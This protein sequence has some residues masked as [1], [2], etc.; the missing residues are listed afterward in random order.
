MSARTFFIIL[1]FAAIA[2]FG[3]IAISLFW[4]TPASAHD[5]WADGNPLPPWV[6]SDCCGKADV[7][8]YTA[9]Q[10][11]EDDNGYHFPDYPDAI[12]AQRAL[13]SQDQYYYVFFARLP[14][15][16]YSSVYCMFA[17]LTF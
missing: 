8:R 9:D 17:P 11:T 3:V 5:Q 2:L 12:P 10:V 14:N 13:P 16:M 15:G 1:L 6:K 4:G 7:H